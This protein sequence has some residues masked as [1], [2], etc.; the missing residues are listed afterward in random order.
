[1]SATRQELAYQVSLT[2][3]DHPEDFDIDGIVTELLQ[4]FGPMESVDDVQG[5]LYWNVVA[6]YDT[7]EAENAS[8]YMHTIE[9]TETAEEPIWQAVIRSDA[10]EEYDGT[11]VD[12][13]RSVLDNW[14]HDQDVQA[15]NSDGRPLLRVIVYR[16][17]D[18]E[19]PAATVT[20]TAAE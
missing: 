5:E 20:V 2:L 8:A 6:A 14:L 19:N 10:P 1:M 3:G 17:D 7:T 18:P 11:A 15:V 16:A 9:A 4:K 12:Y 13:G